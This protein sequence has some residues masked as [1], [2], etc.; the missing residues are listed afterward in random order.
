MTV[1]VAV[2]AEDALGRIGL[3]NLLSAE[4]P[5]EIELVGD[6]HDADVLVMS[7]ESMSAV[8]FTMLRHFAADA[9]TPVVL[10]CADLA[11]PELLAAVDCRVFAVLDQGSVT[12]EL[13]MRTVEVVF[14]GGGVMPPSMVGSLLGHIAQMRRD[15]VSQNVVTNSGLTA[16]EIDVIRLL[17]DGLVTEEIAKKLCFS[18]RTVKNVIYGIM[19]RHGLRNRSHVVAYAMRCGLI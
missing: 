13:L 10:V 2:H 15:M 11:E 14:S 18:E 12:A 7:V 5:D 3:A 9:G 17:A 4:S 19:R 8:A 1:R 16:R 6:R